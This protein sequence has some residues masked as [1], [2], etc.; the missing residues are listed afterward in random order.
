M[1]GM[2]DKRLEMRGVPD[3]AEFMGQDTGLV[4]IA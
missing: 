4:D 3:M 2:S 1:A